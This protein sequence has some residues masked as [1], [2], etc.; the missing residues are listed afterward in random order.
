VRGSGSSNLGDCSVC[1]ILDEKV[2]TFNVLFFSRLKQNYID[3]EKRHAE[4][5]NKPEKNQEV[6]IVLTTCQKSALFF[7][8]L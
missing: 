7:R 2:T 1:Y 4:L 6:P 8:H 5:V 3:R